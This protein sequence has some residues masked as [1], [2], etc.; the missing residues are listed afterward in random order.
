[1]GNK[2]SINAKK[3]ISKIK[4][5]S[6]IIIE[7]HLREDEREVL[8]RIFCNLAE[9]SED[10]T[11]D[12]DTFL[13]FFKLPGILGERLWQKFDKYNTEVIDLEE[14]LLGLALGCKG[15]DNELAK[16]IFDIYDLHG[17]GFVHKEDLVTILHNL[18]PTK[19]VED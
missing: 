19:T 9:R 7:K 4:E 6:R 16:F 12:K 3:T 2:G 11:I 8:V 17:D 15:S 1:M 14:F 5:E 18:K 13:I 10:N